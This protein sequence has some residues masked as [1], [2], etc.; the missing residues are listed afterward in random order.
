MDVREINRR[1]IEQ[2]R[3]GGEIEGMH[4]DRLV[5]LTTVGARS[6]RPHTT[7]M[8]YHRDG[9]RLLVIA[10]NAGAAKHPD[11]Y[12][13]LL[14]NP[15]VTVEVGDETYEAVATPAEGAERAPLW[16]MLKETYP[17]FADHEE[18]SQRVIPVVVLTRIR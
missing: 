7:P 12:H 10:S 8:M 5:L 14:A 3:S 16:T 9:D 13:N 1:V 17:F 11:W 18:K 4:R 6:G 15:R 2:F